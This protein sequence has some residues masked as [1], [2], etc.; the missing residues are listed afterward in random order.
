MD[1][2][3]RAQEAEER[4]RQLALSMHR[5]RHPVG[6]KYFSPLQTHCDDCGEEIPASRRATIPDCI[7]CITCQTELE[8][9][10]NNA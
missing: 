2:F 10:L 1:I 9:K 4:D 8:E 7:R 3:D 6:A 5:Q